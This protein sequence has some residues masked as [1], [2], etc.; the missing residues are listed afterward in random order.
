V[1]LQERRQSRAPEARLA[2]PSRAKDGSPVQPARKIRPIDPR[3]LIPRRLTAPFVEADRPLCCAAAYAPLPLC[4]SALES[5]PYLCL[6]NHQD[7]KQQRSGA[8]TFLASP[9]FL[10]SR[11]ERGVRVGLASPVPYWGRFFKAA[12]ITSPGAGNCVRAR[13]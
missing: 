1:R 3:R 2:S 8:P 7:A 12:Q 9:L 4:P 5:P 13:K 10:P 6:V 11:L